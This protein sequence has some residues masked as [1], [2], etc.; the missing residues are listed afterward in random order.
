[1]PCS[2]CKFHRIRDT[3]MGQVALECVK[4]SLEQLHLTI[5][6]TGHVHSDQQFSH[7]LLHYSMNTV[8]MCLVACGN[9]FSRFRGPE[10]KHVGVAFR[11]LV[12]GFTSYSETMQNPS[13]Q[14]HR[15]WQDKSCAKTWSR[16]GCHAPSPK[17]WSRCRR[18]SEMAD[19]VTTISNS[20]LITLI[21]SG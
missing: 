8:T 1:M 5:K 15:A 11:L 3:A 10:G 19:E 17:Y 6:V 16:E 9:Q 21:P 20:M 2:Q 12:H 4:H 13:L 18:T 7:F 14:L